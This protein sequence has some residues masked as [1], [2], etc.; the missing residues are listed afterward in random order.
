M[1]GAEDI[2]YYLN[3]V[4]EGDFDAINQV[5]PFIYKELQCIAK[6]S[7]YRFSGIDTLNTTA[8]IHEAYLKMW[9]GNPDWKSRNHFFC[10]AAKAMRQVLLNAARSKNT[11]K[12]GEGLSN[13]SIESIENHINLSTAAATK[14]VD[15]EDLLR[16]LEEKDGLYGKIVECRFFAG[17]TIEE[18]AEVL[19]VSSA[20]VKRKWQLARDWMYTHIGNFNYS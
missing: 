20:T 9:N 2:T 17:L 8:L 7:R 15:L 11:V 16:I 3:R 18:T 14:L 4:G 19:G 5:F 13:E 1:A 6:S 10:V 12:R